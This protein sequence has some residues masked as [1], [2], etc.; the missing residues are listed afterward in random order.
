[1]RRLVIKSVVK[2]SGSTGGLPLILV[3]LS[4]DD[5]G[6]MCHVAVKCIEMTQNTDSEGSS[7]S[8]Y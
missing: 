3:T 8:Y 7:Q 5:V 1:M 4:L 2:Y 6:G